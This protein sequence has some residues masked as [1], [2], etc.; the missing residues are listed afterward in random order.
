MGPSAGA[1]KTM[2]QAKLSLLTKAPAACAARREWAM[3]VQSIAARMAL[4]SIA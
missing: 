2:R 4:A 3:A 1:V